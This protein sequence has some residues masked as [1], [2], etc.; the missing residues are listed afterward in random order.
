MLELLLAA[1]LTAVATGLGA[2]PVFM[3]GD[4]AAELRPFLLGLAGGVMTVAS[5]IGL[6]IPALERGSVG[7]VGAGLAIGAAFLFGAR[8]GLGHMRG[9]FPGSG[10][11]S[12]TVVLV[13][14]VLLVHSL[15]E[16]F[17][18]GTAYA[19][20]P[21]TLGLFV[22]AAIAIHN[23]PEGTSVAIPLAAEGASRS[24]QFWSAVLT[25]AP[26]PPGALVAYLLVEE[27]TALLPVSFGFAAGAMFTLVAIELMPQA[28]RENPRQAWAGAAAG[29]V[30]MALLGQALQV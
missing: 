14:L 15:P 6:M 11:A 1:T 2:I 12:R 23:I 16:G 24:R 27:I 9:D 7:E 25:S 8:R 18:V 19:T 30:A 29:G 22:V 5:V 17:A 3:L 28:L 26:Q 13:F 20:D 21:G 10:G 4:R